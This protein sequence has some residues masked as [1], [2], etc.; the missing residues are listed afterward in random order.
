M[1][2]VRFF[3]NKKHLLPGDSQSIM[4]IS[5]PRAT[6][7]HHTLETSQCL[8]ENAIV[9]LI[10]RI[11]FEQTKELKH[12]TEESGLVLFSFNV[13]FLMVYLPTVVF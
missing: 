13:F 10:I 2:S 12:L 1:W 9:E 8:G 7:L 4:N 6:L 11:E 3:D 5:I